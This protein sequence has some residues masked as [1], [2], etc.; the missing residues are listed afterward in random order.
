MNI[1]YKST[2]SISP[3]AMQAL[4]RR[5]EWS[6]WWTLKDIE[7]YLAH[8]LFVV[9]A[10]HGRKLVGVGVLTGDGRINVNLDKLVVDAKYQ[11]QGI[12]TSLLTRLV[13]EADRLAP[14]SFQTDVCEECAER[15]YKRVGFKKN[16]GTWLLHHDPT[17]QRWGPKASEDRKKRRNG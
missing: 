11:R 5:L 7:W 12:G 15:L 17:W 1:T 2:K 16:K 13:S 8:A 6:D 3:R 14:Y 10:W 4:L 9:S